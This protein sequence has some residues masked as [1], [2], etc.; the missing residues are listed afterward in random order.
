MPLFALSVN[1]QGRRTTQR[2][3]GESCS[4]KFLF[5]EH[6]NLR[7]HGNGRVIIA[8]RRCYLCGDR[9]KGTPKRDQEQVGYNPYERAGVKPGM[10]GQ[11]G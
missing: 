9:K 4:L 1:L 5:K 11:V 6:A 3:L 7:G 2:D 10:L 8:E